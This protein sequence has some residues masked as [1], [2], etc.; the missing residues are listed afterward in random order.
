MTVNVKTTGYRNSWNHV[1]C[2]T[3]VHGFDTE[4]TSFSLLL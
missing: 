1:C 3:Y 2:W 4:E